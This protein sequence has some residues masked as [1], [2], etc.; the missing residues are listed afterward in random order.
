MLIRWGI[1]RFP[2]EIKFT[3]GPARLNHRIQLA[4]YSLLL[5]SIHGIAVPHGYVVRLP[6]DSVDKIQIDSTLR[7]LAW[8]TI[9][10]V[11]NTIRHEQLP[12]PIP[13]VSR[14]IDCEYL[15]FCGD[16]L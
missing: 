10:A 9:E 4:G 1:Q 16:V 11:R 15:R 13:Q 3:Q 8:K 12:P 14:C 7:D 5:E 2:V 6:D